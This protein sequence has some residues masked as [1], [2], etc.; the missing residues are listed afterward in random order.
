VMVKMR[1]FSI[2]T[3]L[4]ICKLLSK[5]KHRPGDPSGSLA[6]KTCRAFIQTL[7]PGFHMVDHHRPPQ[8]E[9]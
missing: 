5:I 2:N 1:N 6:S 7:K 8:S 4:I 3:P 9:I